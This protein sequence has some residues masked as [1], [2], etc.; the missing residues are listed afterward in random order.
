MS[1]V[2]PAIREAIRVNAERD[3]FAE[4]YEGFND[5]RYAQSSLSD[6]PEPCDC[7]KAE[8]EI[9]WAEILDQ[10]ARDVSARREGESAKVHPLVSES[11]RATRA[12]FA[13]RAPGPA[14]GGTAGDEAT[15]Y[16]ILRRLYDHAW[17]DGRATRWLAADRIKEAT[18]AL[19]AP[20]GLQEAA[21]EGEDEESLTLVEQV[22]GLLADTP[23][24][25]LQRAGAVIA[26][27]NR[28]AAP[29]AGVPADRARD[30][31][32]GRLEQAV[33]DAIERRERIIDTLNRHP[34]TAA[35]PQAGVEQIADNVLAVLVDE[36]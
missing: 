36:K 25:W 8:A 17:G 12:A 5:C 20:S 16:V 7:G 35:L 18:A 19:A 30:E 27:L 21:G 14:P 24:T 29:P 22:A 10:E 3:H 2:T 26:F 28:P 32:D 31:D 13:T 33:R 34:L 23:G 1:I 11:E 4:A 9:A 6:N 15:V